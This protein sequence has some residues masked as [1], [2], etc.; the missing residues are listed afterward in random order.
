MKWT[1]RAE[2]ESS[3]SVPPLLVGYVSVRS[4]GGKSVF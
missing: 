3:A 2:T 4:Q 1:M